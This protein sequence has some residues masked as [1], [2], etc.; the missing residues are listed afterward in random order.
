MSVRGFNNLEEYYYFILLGARAEW[1]PLWIF[2][3]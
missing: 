2:V 1:L 3:G